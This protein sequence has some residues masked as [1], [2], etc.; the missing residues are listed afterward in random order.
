[1]WLAI[2]LELEF[3]H[4]ELLS[5]RWVDSDYNATYPAPHYFARIK[6]K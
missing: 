6:R 5:T 4:E 3:N 1:M 2:G